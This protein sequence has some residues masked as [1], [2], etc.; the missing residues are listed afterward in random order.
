MGTHLTDDLKEH[1]E[2]KQTACTQLAPNRRFLNAGTL[3]ATEP[4]QPG[5]EAKGQLCLHIPRPLVDQTQ[6]GE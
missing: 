3:T 5:A 2:T 4:L 1:H 6:A